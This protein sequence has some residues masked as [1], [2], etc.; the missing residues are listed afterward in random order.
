VLAVIDA[1]IVS[2]L[3]DSMVFLIKAGEVARKPFLNAVEELR[4]AKAKIVGVLFNELKV[5]R[6]DYHFRDYYRYYRLGYYG[7]EE[8]Q[9]NRKE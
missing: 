9:T 8:K 3:A 7:E 6:G 2:S 4:R 1:V 5:G